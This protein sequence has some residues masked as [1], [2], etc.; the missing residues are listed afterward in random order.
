MEIS[1]DIHKVDGV[2]GNVYIVSKEKNLTVIDTGMPRSCGKILK[3]VEK[4]GRQP[5][6]V[7]TI[8]LTHYHI[9]HVGS[10]H[11]LKA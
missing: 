5:T 7:S 2:N 6:D 8:V 11:D 10:A 3:C 1:K 4:M 9:D